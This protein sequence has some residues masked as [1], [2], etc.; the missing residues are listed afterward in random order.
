MRALV[1]CSQARLLWSAAKELLLLKLLRLH[2]TTWTRDILCDPS[3]TRR[4]R[5]D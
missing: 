4:E 3:Y 5:E 1:E 2:P